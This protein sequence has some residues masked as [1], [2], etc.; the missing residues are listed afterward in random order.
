MIFLFLSVE[1]IVTNGRVSHRG[2][3][4]IG[5]LSGSLALQFAPLLFGTRALY[6]AVHLYR[7]QFELY[8]FLIGAFGIICTLLGILSGVTLLWPP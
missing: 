8:G 6:A 7:V 1:T 2:W 4:A 3:I 5:L